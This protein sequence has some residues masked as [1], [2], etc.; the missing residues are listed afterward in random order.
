MA[1]IICLNGIAGRHSD[2]ICLV[3]ENVI[4]KILCSCVIVCISSVIFCTC[5]EYS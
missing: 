4:I 1:V 3:Q 5:R 2:S